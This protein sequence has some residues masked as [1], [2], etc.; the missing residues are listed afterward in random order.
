ML[1]VNILF[2]LLALCTI[3]MQ[4]QTSFE[5]LFSMLNK[6]ENLLENI[7]TITEV[8]YINISEAPKGIEVEADTLFIINGDSLGFRQINYKEI[9]YRDPNSIISTRYNNNKVTTSKDTIKY[10]ND[11]QLIYESYNSLR[12]ELSRLNYSRKFAYDPDN[13]LTKIIQND[14]NLV[15]LLYHNEHVFD[16]I[17]MVTDLGMRKLSAKAN[18]L[19]DT[20]R[21]IMDVQ[22]IGFLDFMNDKKDESHLEYMDLILEGENLHFYYYDTT[23][24]SKKI[25]LAWER[26]YD[27]N[28]TILEEKREG[29]YHNI[30][31]YN[32]NGDITSKK[33][34][35]EDKIT[36]WQ[37]DQKGNL[38]RMISEQEEVSYRYDDQGNYT[39]KMSFE[40]PNK[41]EPKEIVIRTYN[42]K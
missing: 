30:Y 2:N 1:R 28:Y 19:G 40:N 41:M 18:F 4:A 8:R 38:T 12:P 33:N 42:Y 23:P 27:K 15:N 36:T 31:E 26:I 39:M 16:S 29:S 24:L 11:G 9:S 34:V 10:S 7:E 22:H 35:L 14:Q 25:F 21:Y 37:Y 32:Y 17:E 3:S 6:T 13:R 20:I 5:E